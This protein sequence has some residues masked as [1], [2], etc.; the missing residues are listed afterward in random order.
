[1]QESQGAD[2][3]KSAD[4]QQSVITDGNKP[5]TVKY[6]TYDKAMATLAK[7][8]QARIELEKK[9]QEIEESKM[10]EQGQFKELAMQ[11]DQELKE[12]KEK[13]LKSQAE[14]IEANIKAKVTEVATKYGAYDAS[15]VLK[16]LSLKDLGADVEGNVD[17]KI[18]EQKVE[19][20]RAKKQYLFRQS[21]AKIADGNPQIK[22][23]GAKS[24]D[25]MG[26]N[27]LQKLYMDIALQK[28]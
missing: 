5:Q 12:I 1:M 7:E 25:K 26:V 11:K 24:F 21:A 16:N 20:I 27:D 9:L 19:E 13:M 23:D 17:V 3:T 22:P 10:I 4:G 18:V 2:G 15:D 6:E 8:K 14:K 28:K